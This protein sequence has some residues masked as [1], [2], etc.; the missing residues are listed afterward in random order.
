QYD[1]AD[2]TRLEQFRKRYNESAPA[3]GKL[4][5]TA[6]LLKVCAA[7]LRAFP[8]FNSSLDLAHKELVLDL[9]SGRRAPEPRDEGMTP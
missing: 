1:R 7:A 3:G 2:I 8:R 9:R 5:M 4:T 6:F